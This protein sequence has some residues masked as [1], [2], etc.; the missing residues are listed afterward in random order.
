VI[1]LKEAE[2]NR[3]TIFKNAVPLF[4]SVTKK[5]RKR[6]NF[7]S[8]TQTKSKSFRVMSKTSADLF[9]SFFSHGQWLKRFGDYMVEKSSSGVVI[10]LSTIQQ[11]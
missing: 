3:R 10:V 11:V 2:L 4:F 5:E 1:E 9:L 6:K 8:V 7:P